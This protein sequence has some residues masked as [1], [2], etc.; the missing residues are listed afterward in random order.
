MEHQINHE[1]LRLILFMD[2]SNL[3]ENNIIEE[4]EKYIICRSYAVDLLKVNKETGSIYYDKTYYTKTTVRIQ[5]N[6]EEWLDN[7]GL[8]I[9]HLVDNTPKKEKKPK[10]E[11]TVNEQ[12]KLLGI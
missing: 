2:I 3:S 5:H 4:T 8:I 11:L 12:R 7:N 9:T 6:I 10:R 1:K